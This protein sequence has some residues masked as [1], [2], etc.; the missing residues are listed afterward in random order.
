LTRI[1]RRTNDIIEFRTGLRVSSASDQRLRNH[2]GILAP[3]ESPQVQAFECILLDNLD[4]TLSCELTRGLTDEEFLFRE[5]RINRDVIDA[6]KGHL[7]NL[8]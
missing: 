4:D 7:R 3:A 6:F 1:G 8:Q 2:R 5:Q